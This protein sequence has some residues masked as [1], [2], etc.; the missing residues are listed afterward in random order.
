MMNTDLKS[1]EMLQFVSFGGFPSFCGRG[2][3]R[4][5]PHDLSILKANV[6]LPL[7]QFHTF[8]WKAMGQL[9]T[10]PAISAHV[11]SKMIENDLSCLWF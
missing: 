4:A 10:L 1:G 8:F 7:R 9:I 2:Q 5:T 6:G 11:K 3:T